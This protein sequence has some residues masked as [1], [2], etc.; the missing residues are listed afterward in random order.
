MLEVPLRVFKGARGRRFEN[1]AADDA[2]DGSHRKEH[3][4]GAAQAR[5]GPLGR[6]VHTGQVL[7]GGTRERDR[8]PVCDREQCQAMEGI[9]SNS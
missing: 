6:R 1:A 5:R 8:E 9:F 3:P 4:G 2:S 7:H